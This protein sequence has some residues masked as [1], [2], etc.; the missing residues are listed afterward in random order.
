MASEIQRALDLATDR[1]FIR[2]QSASP[3]HSRHSRRM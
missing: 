1:K 2:S 3:A